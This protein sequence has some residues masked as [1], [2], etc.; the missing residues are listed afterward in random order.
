VKV[1]DAVQEYVV[2]KQALGMSYKGRALKLNTFA[3]FVGPMDLDKVTPEMVRTFLNGHGRVTADW[4]NKFSALN[5]FF[6]FA[7]ARGYAKENPLPRTKPKSPRQFR[8]YIYS[9]EEVK[10]M[11]QVVD[12]RHRGR[13]HL[14]PCTVRTLLLLLYGTGLRIGEAIRLQHRDVDFQDRILTVRESK[15]YKS[16]LVPVSPD[17]ADV[18]QDHF[19]KQWE[20]RRAT[21][22]SPF[23]ATYY[24][25]P[26]THLTAEL[27]F[28][29]I[30]YE[31]GVQR[32]DGFYYQPRLHDFRHTFAVRRLIAWY[33]E[34]KNVQRLLPHLATY[35]GHVSIRETSR[36]LTMTKEL[37]SEAGQWFERYASQGGMR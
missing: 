25:R 10:K 26:V 19:R 11:I 22:K 24:G 29:K 18:L 13:W 12:C 7:I 21:P 15:F 30:R 28:K 33:R 34:G 2:Y 9:V 36:Y 20:G 32:T 17:L 16:R 31:A 27:A 6:P 8:P 23:F 35:L 4:F 14:E 1:A 5:T 37:L 3:R